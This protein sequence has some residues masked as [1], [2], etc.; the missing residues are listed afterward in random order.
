LIDRVGETPPLPPNWTGQH[1]R[2]ICILDARNYT[3][4]G[5]VAKIR[6]AFPNI[7]G[8]L[9][10]AMIDKRL[11]QLDQNVYVDYWALGLSRSERQR[12][13]GALSPPGPSSSDASRVDSSSSSTAFTADAHRDGHLR[14]NSGETRAGFPPLHPSASRP[15]DSP[16]NHL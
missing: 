11:R 9:T 14:Y 2:A 3:H 12:T 8:T 1:D 7:R 16:N 15:Q 10:P 6:R 4:T 13:V 5:I